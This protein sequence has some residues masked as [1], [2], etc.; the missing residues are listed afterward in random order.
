MSLTHF[1]FSPFTLMSP[2]Q[3]YGWSSSASLALWASPESGLPLWPA[4][5]CV[6]KELQ[7]LTIQSALLIAEDNVYWMLSMYCA[8]C[9]GC[10]SGWVLKNDHH[11]TDQE[12]TK[13]TRFW[14]SRIGSNYSNSKSTP[15]LISPS[16][17]FV[18][19]PAIP[20]CHPGPCHHQLLP[21]LLQGNGLQWSSF[22]FP[23]PLL[24]NL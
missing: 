6:F 21:G 16:T 22:L 13:I 18:E 15:H 17:N 12:T 4:P 23:C 10:S 24:K 11:F 7:L 19:N 3:V 8:W 14:F 9:Q 5:S 20:C 2:Q 1:P